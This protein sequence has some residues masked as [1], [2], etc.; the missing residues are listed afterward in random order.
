MTSPKLQILARQMARHQQPERVPAP[1]TSDLGAALEA[2]IAQRVDEALTKEREQ[3]PPPRVQRVF[4]QFDAPK[5]YTDF[6]Q[7]EPP[8]KARVPKA[9]E[10]HFQRDELGRINIVNAGDMQWRVQRNE[11]GDIVRLVPADIAPMPPAIEPPALAA[12]RAYKPPAPR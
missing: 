1:D 5:P 12:S 3:R 9:M 8:P 10:L 6:R 7:I 11:L 2:L 4:D